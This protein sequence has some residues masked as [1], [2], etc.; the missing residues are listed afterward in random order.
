MNSIRPRLNALI[1]RLSALVP[2]RLPT[3][4]AA[5]VAWAESICALAGY[6]CNSS[7]QQ[8]LAI[9]LLHLGP[10]V[11]YK[12]KEFFIRSLHKA[13]VNQVASGVIEQI[14]EEHKKGQLEPQ[15]VEIPNT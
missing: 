12:P 13:A 2:T 7:F 11:A 3:T 6:P 5:H 8:A 15:T 9:M 4:P 1:A 14:R 10:T